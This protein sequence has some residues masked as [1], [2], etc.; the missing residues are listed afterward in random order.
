V[1]SLSSMTAAIDVRI[2]W[3]SFVNIRIAFSVVGL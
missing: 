2:T 1:S 3:L